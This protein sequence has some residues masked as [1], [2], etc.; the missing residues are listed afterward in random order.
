MFRTT[1][2]NATKSDAITANKNSQSC[3]DQIR[4]ARKS[5]TGREFQYAAHNF[6]LIQ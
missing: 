1:Y 5:Y 3:F 4:V 2:E 6:F